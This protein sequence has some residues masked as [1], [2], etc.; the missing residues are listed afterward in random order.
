MAGAIILK[1]AGILLLAKLLGEAFKKLHLPSLLGELV[2]G[3]ILGPAVIGWIGGEA[4]LDVVAEIGIILAIFL[5]GY[6]QGN[7]SELLQY[8]QTSLTISA[9]SSTIPI[10]AVIAITQYQGYSLL[11][12]LFLA[13][14][15][16]ATSMGVSLRSLM[17]VDETNT[18]IGKTVIGS[19]VANDITGLLLLTGVATYADI[20][21]G[22]G[23]NITMQILE[24]LGGVALCFLTFYIGIKTVPRLSH[25]FLDLDVEQAQFS[26]AVIIILVLAWFASAFGLSSIIGAFFAGLI[27]SRSPVFE[28]KTF[29][30]KVLSISYGFFV[31]VFFVMTGTHLEFAN[32]F[33]NALRA[34]LF[35]AVITPLQIGV[36]Y[37]ASRFN[38]YT[39]REGL[40]VGLGMLPYGEVTLVVMTALLGL[41]ETNPDVFPGDI[42]GL[43]SS[44]LVLILFTVIL[45]PTLMKLVNKLLK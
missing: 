6:E 4:F 2:A 15:L 29:H 33:T 13:V 1:L 3:I 42:S 36:G 31:P 44:V 7:I 25:S 20:A 18:K 12:S 37:A 32:F 27:L 30:E 34:L 19:L 38:G 26:L 39:D 28:T 10:F 23:G 14:A 21:T 22:A 5:A 35:L 24:S 41:V 17:G 40:L 16:G 9:L 45:A 8:K 11:T 43:F